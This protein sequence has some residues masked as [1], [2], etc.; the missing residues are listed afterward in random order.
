MFNKGVSKGQKEYSSPKDG[1][2]RRPDTHQLD[3]RTHCYSDNKK[4]E[5]SSPSTVYISD[6][7]GHSVVKTSSA[8]TTALSTSSLRLVLYLSK[9]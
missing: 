2:D 4:K 3:S 9:V 7:R 1:R 6:G 5:Y 8:N